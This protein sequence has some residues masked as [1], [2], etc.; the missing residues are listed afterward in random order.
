MEVPMPLYQRVLSKLAEWSAEFSASLVWKFLG[1]LSASILI[2]APRL[3]RWRRQRTR[4]QQ[5]QFVR[6]PATSSLGWLSAFFSEVDH[7][8][9]VRALSFDTLRSEWNEA[10]CGACA[11]ISAQNSDSEI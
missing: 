2:F 3:S 5:A 7:S 1:W 4:A 10:V 8:W 11:K 6:F 9:D